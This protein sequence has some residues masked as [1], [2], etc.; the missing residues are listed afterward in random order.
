MRIVHLIWQLQ[1]GG[2][3]AMLVDIV[4]EQSFFEKV[5]LIVGNVLRD[6]TLLGQV[7]QRVDIQLLGRPEGSRNP[8]YLLK[9]YRMLE[10]IQPDIIHAH[11]DSF[12]RLLKYIRSPR[13]L[14]LHTTGISLSR[15]VNQY[16]AVYCISDAV[17]CDVEKRY[18]RISTRVIQNGISFSAMRQKQIYGHKPFR[19]VQVSRLDHHQKGQDILLRAMKNVKDTLGGGQVTLDFIGEGTSKDYLLKLTAELGLGDCCRFLG[20]LPRSDVYANMHSYDL[21]VQPSRFEGF[22]L[23]VVEA[24]AAGLP[25][26][27]SDIEGPMEIIDRGRYG[28]F[29]RSEDADDCAKQIFEIMRL[30]TLPEFVN[31]RKAAEQYV[32]S[33]YDVATTAQNYIADYSRVIARRKS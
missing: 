4:N 28:Y 15:Q 5:T 11:Q 12:I 2:A 18:P 13:V 9:L 7:S 22:G 24:M 33:T 17:R 30:S 1:L 31:C 27:V 29:F 26:L 20:M 6:K 21:L 23:T 10:K 19:M 14:T 8:W 3:E 32:K 16:D 25:V